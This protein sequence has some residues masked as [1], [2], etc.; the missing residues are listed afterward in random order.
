[1]SVE[2]AKIAAVRLTVV[3]TA[4]LIRIRRNFSTTD[5]NVIGMR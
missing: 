3:R 4:V 2:L 5:Y 1:M